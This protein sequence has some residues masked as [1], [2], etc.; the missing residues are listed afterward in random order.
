MFS[1]CVRVKGLLTY[2][3]RGTDTQLL[4]KACSSLEVTVVA[5]GNGDTLCRARLSALLHR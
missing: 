3:L 2:C 1:L 4:S 5:G